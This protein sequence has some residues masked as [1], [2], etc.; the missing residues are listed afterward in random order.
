MIIDALE[1]Y[2][3]FKLLN[4]A[5]KRVRAAYLKRNSSVFS[6]DRIIH[7]RTI[8]MKDIPGEGVPFEY[9]FMYMW[10]F[11]TH[12]HTRTLTWSLI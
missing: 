4:I 3:V 7:W 12:T 5:I 10:R 11:H 2:V 8:Q 9:K 6:D 1:R